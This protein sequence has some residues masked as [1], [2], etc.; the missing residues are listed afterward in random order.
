MQQ[1]RRYLIHLFS[2]QTISFDIETVYNA[3]VNI[4]YFDIALAIVLSYLH[5]IFPKCPEL[6]VTCYLYREVY[7]I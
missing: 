3:N 7:F 4:E 6:H 5:L 2:I 1:N